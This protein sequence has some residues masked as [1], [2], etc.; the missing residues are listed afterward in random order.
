MADDRLSID[1]KLMLASHF[2]W[3]DDTVVTL[4]NEVS[5][6]TEQSRMAMTEL[7]MDGALVMAGDDDIFR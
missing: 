5:R 1:A 7:M 6:M 3:G 4:G 2:A